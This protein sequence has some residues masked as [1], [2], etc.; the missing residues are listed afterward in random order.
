MKMSLMMTNHNLV[1]VS[2]RLISN[3]SLI[4]HETNTICTVLQILEIYQT[5]NLKKK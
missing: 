3:I 1:F 4:D 5:W 2:I